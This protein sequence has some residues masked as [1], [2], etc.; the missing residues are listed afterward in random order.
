MGFDDLAAHHMALL[1]MEQYGLALA[2]LAP[3]LLPAANLSAIRRAWRMGRIPV[4]APTHMLAAGRPVPPVWD[5]TSDS[6]A[7][8]LARELGAAQLLLIKSADPALDAALTLPN[9]AE[10]GMVDCLFPGFAG[11]CGAEIT[12]AGPSALEGAAAIFKA[13]G[14]PGTRVAASAAT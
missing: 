6:L 11:T 13:G 12:I 1:A 10:A 8:W 5:M 2:A 9:L 14:V 3:R 4:W 7:A